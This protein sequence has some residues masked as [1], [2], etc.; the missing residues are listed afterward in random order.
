MTQGL[1]SWIFKIKD[2]MPV[3]YRLADIFVLPSVRNETWGLAINEAMVCGRPVIA[4]NKVG[5]SPDLI[6]QGRTGWSFEPG[7]KGETQ[8]AFMLN[9]FCGD[10]SVLQKVGKKA[11]NWVQE[12]SYAAILKSVKNLIKQAAKAN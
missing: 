3:V 12:Y 5:C 9:Q 7:E 2:A 4:S 10:R 8:I 1:F 6:I 11:S